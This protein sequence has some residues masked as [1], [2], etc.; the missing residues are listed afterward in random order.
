MTKAI[1]FEIQESDVA[2]EIRRLARDYVS[3]KKISTPPTTLVAFIHPSRMTNVQEPIILEGGTVLKVKTT[4][5]IS[6]NKVMFNLP[7][8]GV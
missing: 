7:E 2:G 5:A 4:R 8:S 3:L 1:T 6:P